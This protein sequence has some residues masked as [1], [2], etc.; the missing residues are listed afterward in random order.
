M[1]EMKDTTRQ[2]GL[3]MYLWGITDGTRHHHHHFGWSDSLAD[4]ARH[5]RK[6]ERVSMPADP[7]RPT[8]RQ[9]TKKIKIIRNQN[10]K[11]RKEKKEKTPARKHCTACRERATSRHNKAE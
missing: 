9:L 11:E 7:D 4:E 6:K 5:S 8:D 2:S 10:Q 1:E 3:M